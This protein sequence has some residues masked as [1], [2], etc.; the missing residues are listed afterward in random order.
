MQ[1]HLLQSENILLTAGNIAGYQSQGTQW[2]CNAHTDTKGR[3]KIHIKCIL[4]LLCIISYWCAMLVE[5]YC[6]L[7]VSAYVSTVSIYSIVAVLLAL[8]LFGQ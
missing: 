2:T 1:L 3:V 6:N 4:M 5:L 8:I 7:T